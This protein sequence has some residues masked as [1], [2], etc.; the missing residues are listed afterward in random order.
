[1]RRS[2]E[3]LERMCREVGVDPEKVILDAV[4]AQVMPQGKLPTEARAP[5]FYEEFRE[6][7]RRFGLDAAQADAE[8]RRFVP[9][10]LRME[11]GPEL[12]GFRRAVR[13][14]LDR[15]PKL[16]LDDARDRAESIVSPSV[17]VA[18]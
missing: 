13:S 5:Q 12:E 15:D 10:H 17:R 2:F 18:A 1:M 14:L 8:A 6:G 11:S 7:Y 16:S 3:E 4:V 9:E